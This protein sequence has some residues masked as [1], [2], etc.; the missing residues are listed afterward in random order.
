M[1]A[2][3]GNQNTEMKSIMTL[4]GAIASGRITDDERI[5]LYY[6]LLKG[7][8]KVDITAIIDWLRINEIRDIN[9][10]NAFEMLSIFDCVTLDEF[11]LK[12]EIKTF[13]DF[14]LD[15]TS[16]LP[17]LKESVD[18]HTKLASDIFNHLWING[19]MYS[20]VLRLFVAYIIDEKACSFIRG[21]PKAKEEIKRIKRWQ[22]NNDLDSTLSDGYESQLTFFIENGLVYKRSL[23]RF[24]S[25]F[26]GYSY[27]YTIYNLYPS[28]RELLFNNSEPYQDFLNECKQS[29]RRISRQG[30]RKGIFNP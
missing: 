17:M 27:T 5:V 18:R 1:S 3:S 9:V 24:F 12:F 8:R 25:T 6:M 26:S 10:E 20:D 4:Q 29:H 22:S 16:M 30:H 2:V 7:V 19:K 21:F 13:R 28:I 15:K 23:W 11:Q 14:I